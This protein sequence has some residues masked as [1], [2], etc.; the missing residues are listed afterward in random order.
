MTDEAIHYHTLDKRFIHLT[1]LHATNQY[2]NKKT[3]ATTNSIESI[4]ALM[5]R[6]IKGFIT[7]FLKNT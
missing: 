1:T 3:G 5:T 2:V 7:I 4:W 6:G